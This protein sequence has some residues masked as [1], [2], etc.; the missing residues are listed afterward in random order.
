MRT[1][2]TVLNIIR[3][4]G[5]RGL[6]LEDV[7]RQLYNP[8]LYLRA[9]GNIYSNDGANT[10]GITK[11]TID[12]MS[13]AQINTIIDALRQERYRWTPVR[14]TYILK[15]NG[16]K[17]PLGIPTWSDKLLQEVIRS[18]FEAY[19]EPQFSE[20]SHGFRAGRGCHTALGQITQK[21]RATTWFIEGDIKGC[22]D[23]IDHKVLMSILRRK[24][25]DNRLLRLIENLLEAGYLED[26]KYHSTPSGTPQGG[27]VSPILANIYL[28]ELD[29]YVE[30]TLIPE[31]T[32]GKKRALNL[33]YYVIGARSRRRKKSGHYQEAQELRKQFQSMPA[34]DMQDP[35]Y[36]RL[37]YV[38]YA[39]DFLLGFIGPKAEAEEIKGK[40]ATFL[41]DHLK[42]ELSKEKTLITSAYTDMAHFLGYDIEVVLKDTKHNEKGER[43]VNGLVQL[44]VPAKVVE[45]KCALYMQRGKPYQRTELID[46]EDFSI[47]N[48]YQTEYRGTVQ[49]YSLASNLYWFHKLEWVMQGSLLRTLSCKNKESCLSI[50]KRYTSTIK[51]PHGPRTC[52]ELKKAREGKKTQVARFGGIPLIQNKKAILLDETPLRY[53]PTNELIRRLLADVGELCGSTENIE[54]HH[55]RKLADLKRKD[56]RETPAWKSNMAMRKRKTLVT[57]MK[58][59]HDIHNGKSTGQVQT[60]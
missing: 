5:K 48:R 36:R 28:N 39:D 29:Q 37:R 60:T 32:K 15:K 50:T 13:M 54:V 16:K 22:F 3:E 57:C 27:I 40:L 59:H 47:I 33:E 46:D 38:R 2:D 55:I 52:L 10:P 41:S 9:Y 12:G 20:Q 30:E 43:N 34:F 58:R 44:R 42:L 4:R 24:I 51:T 56:G 7:Y 17:R 49:Y 6:Q 25:Q 8:D 19:Y 18:I 1:A 21:W 26:W 53:V 11:E 31:N 45:E 14:R 35:E 23:N